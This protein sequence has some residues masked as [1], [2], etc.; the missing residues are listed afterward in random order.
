MSGSAKNIG[1]HDGARQ[2]FRLSETCSPRSPDGR[3]TKTT[4]KS[5]KATTSFQAV[6]AKGHAQSFHEPQHESPEHGP[7]AR[8]RCRPGRRP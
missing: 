7:R 3:T 5:L 6:R 4:I 1:G 2:D 8:C